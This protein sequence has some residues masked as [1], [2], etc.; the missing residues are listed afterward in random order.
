MIELLRVE[1]IKNDHGGHGDLIFEISNLTGRKVF[2]SYYFALTE[3]VKNI[4]DVKN[5]VS[6][7]LAYWKDKIMKSKNGDRIFLPIDFSDQYT[8]CLR[9]EKKAS[10]LKLTYGFSMIEGY[11]VNP[12]NPS[13][14]YKEVKDFK[15]GEKQI[16]VE[17][18]LMIAALEQQIS[19]LKNAR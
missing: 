16:T 11:A 1:I 10:K 8:G 5:A 6:K 14:Y 15:A 9:V 17:E 13:E 2:D 4:N 18:S 12:S 19:K 7:L 3:D